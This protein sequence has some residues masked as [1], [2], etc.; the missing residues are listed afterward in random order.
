M[1]A[2]RKELASVKRHAGDLDARTVG[3]VVFGPAASNL[4]EREAD[5]RREAAV[6][7]LKANLEA[8]PEWVA[9]RDK[10]KADLAERRRKRDEATQAF[11]PAA[12]PPEGDVPPHPTGGGLGE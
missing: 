10:L 7:E 6:K 11:G 1:T 2:L 3:S 4:R 8:N 5:A 12:P 9:S